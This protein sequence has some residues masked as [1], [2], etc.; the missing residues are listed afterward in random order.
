MI[1]ADLLKRETFPDFNLIAGSE[2]LQRQVKSVSV[3][4]SPSVDLWMKG[5]EFLIGSGF[6]FKENPQDFVPFIRKCKEKGV[7]AFGIK[8][9]R[10]HSFLP[11]TL[12]EDADNMHFPLIE[13][14]FNY[15]W[16][17]INEIFYLYLYRE[18]SEKG[19]H[20]G[21]HLWE[22]IWDEKRLLQNLASTLERDLVVNIPKLNLSRLFPSDK[23]DVNFFP[24]GE[25]L[26]QNPENETVISSRGDITISIEIK[27]FEGE[28]RNCCLFTFHDKSAMQ[29]CM[30]M[31]NEEYSPSI[32]QERTLVKAL[33]IL[34]HSLIELQLYS[35]HKS[36]KTERFLENLCHGTYN[37]A[38]LARERG[39]S[40]GIN[41]PEP[42]RV[43]GVTSMDFNSSAYHPTFDLCFNLADQ[44]VCIE[45]SNKIE[46][47]MERIK[48]EAKKRDLLVVIGSLASS[49]DDIGESFEEMRKAM[50]W[51]KKFK[52]VQNVHQSENL[53]FYILL[54]RMAQL[55]ESQHLMKRYWFPLKSCSNRKTLPLQEVARA[56][57]EANFNAKKCAENIHIHYNTLRN[58][59]E[60]IERILK[61][62]LSNR[63]HR[64]ALTM[65]CF[66]SE[67]KDKG[68]IH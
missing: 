35:K 5:G 62:D 49:I 36:I 33:W 13:I 42:C 1:V 10:Y 22:E 6:V 60:D 58:Y 37:D 67:I 47:E 8:L 11:D 21:N 51:L 32:T 56:L 43:V 28:K 46:R 25:F 66:I 59:I 57:I 53:S 39:K 27:T 44:W 55:P 48:K 12:V 16:T 7:A 68:T 15:T 50:R 14:P 38:N 29:I 3:M 54:S 61:L 26:Q 9:D 20:E 64:T 41:L 19:L 2:G 40:L 45:D 34:R 30:I 52:P 65:A 31:K 4:D 63:F 18:Q 23:R 24:V 17:D